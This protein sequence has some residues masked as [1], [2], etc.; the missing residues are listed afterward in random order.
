MVKYMIR[1]EHDSSLRFEQSE[2]VHQRHA[3]YSGA[4]T[5]A[6]W[7]VPPHVTDLPPPPSPAVPA[8]LHSSA[9]R[10]YRRWPQPLVLFLRFQLGLVLAEECLDLRCTLQDAEP[11]F[12]VECD[13]KATHAIQRNRA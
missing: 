12:L 9:K 4:A 10:T 1:S 13:R 7:G 6:R 5:P 2:G 3:L 8:Q 11:L